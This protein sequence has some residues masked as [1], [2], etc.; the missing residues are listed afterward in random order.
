[1]GAARDALLLAPSVAPP[2]PFRSNKEDIFAFSTD[3]ANH[4]VESYVPIIEKH[5]NDPYSPRQK[6]WQQIRRGRYTEVSDGRGSVW[7]ARVPLARK[8]V[9]PFAGNA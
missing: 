4:I 7:H 9:L 1:M 3:A 8:V 6:E 2:L 5:K